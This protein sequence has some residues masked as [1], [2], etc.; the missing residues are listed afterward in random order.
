MNEINIVVVGGGTAGWL[1]ALF[2]QRFFPHAKITLIHDD[3]IDIIGV[4]ESTTPPMVQLFDFLGISLAE[5]HKHCGAT[6]KN[7]VRFTN[8]NGDGGHYNHGFNTEENLDIYA[9]SKREI[10]TNHTVG[11][12]AH[13]PLLALSEMF[14]GNNLDSIHFSAVMSHQDKVPF[15]KN[16]DNPQSI[17]DFTNVSGYGLHFNAREVAKYL[18]K[19]GKSR[20]IEVIIGKVEESYIDDNGYITKLLLDNKQEIDCNFII[21]CTGFSRLFVSKTYKSPFISFAKHL[22][23]K[24]AMP[25]FLKRE[26]S[27]PTFTEAVAMK[28]GWMWKIPVGDRFGCGYVFDSD[29]ITDDQAYKEIC[30]VTGQHPDIPKIISF[31]PGYF[32]KPWNKNTLAIGLSSGFLEPLEATSIWITIISLMLFA[33]NIAGFSARDQDAIDEYNTSFVKSVKSILNLV[34]FHYLTPRDDTE[35]WKN[36]TK[37]NEAPE[38]LKD[39]TDILSY[40]TPSRSDQGITRQFPAES[41]FYCTAGQKYFSREIIEKEYYTYNVDNFV[42]DNESQIKDNINNLAN[43]CV[44]HEEFLNSII[45]KYND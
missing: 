24:R 22:P 19:I 11:V 5:L 26:G 12:Q 8:W 20:N 1:S 45:K 35:F 44:D 25:F 15:T 28:Y 18:E 27:I 33:E 10:F 4:G 32:T 3:K 36:F 23:V 38:S 14:K 9:N 13:K 40:R 7:T 2:A 41:W 43:Q 6:I 30:E 42:K 37:N 34:Y 31:E 17:E 16:T 39:L 21:D 29:Y